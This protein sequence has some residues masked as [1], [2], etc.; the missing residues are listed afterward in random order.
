M[1]THDLVAASHADEVV[2]LSDGRVGDRMTNPT[3]D[4]VLDRMKAFECR[5]EHPRT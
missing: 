2:F 1:V 4:K 3:A 5:H